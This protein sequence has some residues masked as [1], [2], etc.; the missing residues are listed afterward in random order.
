M[1]EG[2]LLRTTAAKIIRWHAAEMVGVSDR[3]W[4][5]G[6]SGTKMVAI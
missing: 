5:I 1:T 6:G 2:V 4:A 3:R